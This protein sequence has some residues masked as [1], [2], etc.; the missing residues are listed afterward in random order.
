MSFLSILEIASFTIKYTNSHTFS[1]LPHARVYDSIYVY[2]Y[3]FAHTLEPH[4]QIEHPAS[5]HNNAACIYYTLF[6]FTNAAALCLGYISH[7]F[8]YAIAVTIFRQVSFNCI[9]QLNNR[10]K[11]DVPY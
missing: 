6:F 3:T 1:T 7:E 10:Q 5:T 8:Y 11:G 2:I 9:S 4:A